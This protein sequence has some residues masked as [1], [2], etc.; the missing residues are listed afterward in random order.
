MRCRLARRTCAPLVLLLVVTAMASPAGAERPRIYALTG[1]TV[2]PEPGESLENA[3]VLIRDG[4]IEA[5]GTD[6]TVPPDAVEIDASGLW[7]YP[8]LIDPQTTLGIR[9]ESS[10]RGPTSPF[11]ES[12]ERATP[13]ANHPVP[14]IHPERRVLD[15]LVPFEG[16]GVR[17][18]ERYRNLGYTVALAVP[19]DGIFRGRSVAILLQDDVAVAD[20]VL[21]DDVAQHVGFGRARGSYPGS[22]MGV[23]AA[24]RQAL[25]D[26][27]RYTVWAERYAANPVGMRRPDTLAAYAALA[28]VL[29]GAQP[30]V[31]ALEDPLDLEL[32]DAL[33]DEFDL[34][35][36]ISATG[37]EWAMASRVAS[38]GH[39]LILPLARPDEPEV[40]D[41]DDALDVSLREMRAYLEAPSA[42][43][44]FHEAGV[45]LA[46]TT[47]GLSSLASFG[48]NLRRVIERGLPEDAAL[49][50][51]TTVPAKILGIDSVAGT[52]EPGK[53]AN[54]VVA[55]GPLFAED[56]KVRR[57]YV[58]GREYRVEQKEK[59]TG[60]PNAVVDPRGEWSVTF[61]FGRGAAERTWKI[62]GERGAYKGSAE[63]RTGTVDFEEITLEGNV[64]TVT[65]PSRGG[66]STEVTVVVEG[67]TF[68]GTAEMGPRSITLEGTR[69]SGPEGGGQ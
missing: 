41:D 4:L 39:A 24:I 68:H 64:M 57:I 3:A 5:V 65:F 59:P 45:E 21:R 66:F 44:R 61:D 33:A 16:D 25:L 18:V 58:D 55:D 37:E 7:I 22:L 32:V 14:G 12:E 56:T 63:T 48:K 47:S 2:V 29:S 36:V 15:R 13:G 31:F 53:I 28:P 19:E 43:A 10:E 42:P 26:G 69:I 38:A 6:V 52:L 8:G 40:D 60:D 34:L 17:Q 27:Q 11:G 35:A 9:G 54:V 62:E 67:D 46:L 51:L 50:A 30:V 1:A 49:A 20:M 23:T